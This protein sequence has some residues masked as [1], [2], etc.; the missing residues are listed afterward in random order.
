MDDIDEVLEDEGLSKENLEAALELARSGA[1]VKA[2][3]TFHGGL[4]TPTPKDAKNIHSKLLIL[5]G[6]MDPYVNAAEVAGFM[7]EMND[8][9]VDY[10]LI[11]YAGAVHSFSDP[12]SGNDP[13]KGAAYHAVADKRSFSAM[14]SFFE[15]VL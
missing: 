6:A 15:D 12:N 2:V 7:K 3:V 13:S 4:S 8:A 10:Q 1:K 11:H 14:K 9:K 5:H